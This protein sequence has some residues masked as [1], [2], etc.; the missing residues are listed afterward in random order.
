[1]KHRVLAPTLPSEHIKLARSMS[2]CSV[3]AGSSGFLTPP[4]SGPE[5]T[6]PPPRPENDDYLNVHGRHTHRKSRHEGQLRKTRENREGSGLSD[7]R[8]RLLASKSRTTSSNRSV[9]ESCGAESNSNGVGA[10]AEPVLMKDAEPLSR[11]QSALEAQNLLESDERQM[12]TLPLNRDSSE[13]INDFESPAVDAL[14]RLS[15]PAIATGAADSHSLRRMSR[16][17]AST[18]SLVIPK[19]N[20]EL[21][22]IDENDSNNPKQVSRKI[23][24]E[25]R[26]FSYRDGNRRRQT[27]KDK[28]I[29][30]GMLDTPAT[31]TLR[32]ASNVNT[33]GSGLDVR[34]ALMFNAC[35]SDLEP[36]APKSELLAF[37]STPT[38]ELSNS[39][40]HDSNSPVYT[41]SSVRS[42][43]GD[44]LD[45][46]GPLNDRSKS[47]SQLSESTNASRHGALAET[48][49]TFTDVHLAPGTFGVGAKSRLSLDP[50]E[51]PR[52]VS[53]LHFQTRKSVHE[54]IWREDETTSGSS[55][56][57][58]S[59]VSATPPQPT[60]SFGPDTPSPE[61]KRSPMQTDQAKVIEN[62]VPSPC[63]FD[64]TREHDDSSAGLFQWSWSKT[65]PFSG[66]PVQTP[67]PSQDDV[68]QAPA[69]SR[70][71]PDLTSLAHA[72]PARA[73][74]LKKK[75][76]V[77]ESIPDI[78]SFPP[79]RSRG[80]TAEWT[81]APLVDL[82][83]PL[84][85]REVPISDDE[86][87]I[88]V[89]QNI[90]D[91]TEGQLKKKGKERKRAG[92]EV[93]SLVGV[94]SHRRLL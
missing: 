60:R 94:S 58:S 55:L 76:S 24:P 80:T 83:D 27:S 5:S 84:A 69:T 40:S 15:Q 32:K 62:D 63:S 85:G 41:G 49:L 61:H 52:R 2:P 59:R 50:A 29:M 46:L 65:S 81:R 42:R 79:L 51:A 6:S 75:P 19:T 7:A 8:Q 14:R 91:A 43:A 1:M 72:S 33:T 86:Y 16:A 89:D 48:A 92:L 71:E 64:H 26:S 57:S 22:V 47:I 53:V 3:N 73:L 54:V 87:E 77:F 70:S 23:S 25:N 35:A 56:E 93:G 68:G 17:L 13:T 4:V 88:D 10:G 67:D 34:N 74:K 37:Y 9:C 11:R 21:H 44:A 12:L 30:A 28:K 36:D 39:K 90:V 31:I 20:S 82:N 66:T 78:Q 45:R 18:L 38:F